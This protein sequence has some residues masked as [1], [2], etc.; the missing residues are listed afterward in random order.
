MK[1]FLFVL[2]VFLLGYSPAYAFDDVPINHLHKEAIEYLQ[3]HGIIEGYADGTYKPENTIN[4]AEFTK[5]IIESTHSV[6]NQDG[7]C[8]P[9]VRGE[10]F[11]PY[12]CTAKFQGVISGYPNGFFKPAQSINIVEAAKILAISFH[13]DVVAA[14]GDAW[15]LPYTDT[16][17]QF[18]IIPQNINDN[19]HKITRGEMAKMIYGLLKIAKTDASSELKSCPGMD[20]AIALIVDPIL[21]DNIQSGLR[22]FEGDLC[23]A[24]YTV[25][26]KKSNFTSAHALRDYL[27]SLYGETNQQLEGAILIGNLPHA[28]QW[29]TSTSAN[30]AIPP[31]KEEVIS[32][33]YYSDLDGVFSASSGYRSPG[34]H[35]NSFDR[36]TGNTNW[37][38]WVSSLPLYT[39][40]YANTVAAINRYFDKNHARRVTQPGFTHSFLEINEHHHASTFQEHNQLMSGMRQG[41]YAWTP[42]SNL[43][44]AQ[45][46]FNSTSENLSVDSGYDLLSSGEIDFTVTAT[47]GSPL[48]NGKI[49]ISWV[50]TH[51]INTTFFWSDGC[52]VG[53]LDY[54]KNFLSSVLY[55]STSVVLLA[56]GTT[57][58]SGG[59]GT[60]E[61][62][63]YGHNV[64]TAL[65]N[66][67][68]LGESVLQHVN[69]PLIVP[70]S[71]SREFHF[72][73][74][75]LLG[76]PTL[77]MAF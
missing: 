2:V 67:K 31:V 32:F 47:H 57:N 38:I 54:K 48:K 25:I 28:Y 33:Q 60:N 10:W 53:N 6:L 73:T 35:P 19:A 63:F 4:R 9:D 69:T 61:N 20:K 26:E 11:A 77:K 7:N 62:G 41:Q 5:I 56:K 74:V 76:D 22:R 8:F 51:P 55:S 44:G 24:H 18:N 45:L 15:F 16:L 13:L 64:A 70:W 27:V 3:N 37:E 68:S 72:A 46:Y 1:H 30:P 75:V 34:G 36:H 23:S 40:D 65:S 29:I 14:S 21:F 66:G 49:D 39:G 42:L 58:D 17:R 71:G 52:A 59:M 12:I 43:P 50:E